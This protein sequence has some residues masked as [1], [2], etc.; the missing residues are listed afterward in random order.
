[1][2]AMIPLGGAEVEMNAGDGEVADYGGQGEV[3]VH[4]YGCDVGSGLEGGVGGSV[5]HGRAQAGGGRGSWVARPCPSMR[6]APRS[7]NIWQSRKHG[8]LIWTRRLR[9]GYSSVHSNNSE[10][11]IL[12]LVCQTV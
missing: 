1:M 9:E 3:V 8:W 12:A 2:S 10:A 5:D 6:D 4:D 11:R 7:R